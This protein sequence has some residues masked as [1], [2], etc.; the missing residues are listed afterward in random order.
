M[1]VGQEWEFF[2]TGKC[3]NQGSIGK[4]ELGK[5]SGNL[6]FMKDI[7][8]LFGGSSLNVCLQRKGLIGFMQEE[9]GIAVFVVLQQRQVYISSQS[10]F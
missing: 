9:I 5:Y 7:N 10:A 1:E 2:S 8:Y 4:K 6:G 3:K